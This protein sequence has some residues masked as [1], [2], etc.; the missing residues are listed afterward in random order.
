MRIDTFDITAP[1]ISGETFSEAEALGSAAWL[2]MHS[3]AHRDAPLQV[4]SAL[5]MPSLKTHQFLLATE[6]GKPIFYM[7]WANM[8]EAAEARYLSNPPYSM[9]EADW[10]CGDRM[11]ILDWVAPFGHTQAM[12][13][14]FLGQLFPQRWMHAL[15]HR[16]NE[17]GLRIKTYRGNA[18]MPEEARHWF[19]TH[20]V[21]IPIANKT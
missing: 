21:A 20:P 1:A 12:N 11:W 15:D 18:M 16:G 17:R 4:L 9:P 8:D 13:R 14:L 3:A 5:L 6:Q 19:N 7:A 2:W 10:N